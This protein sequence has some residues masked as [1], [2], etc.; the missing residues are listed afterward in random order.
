MKIV[1]LNEHTPVGNWGGYYKGRAGELGLAGKFML[2]HV[3]EYVNGGYGLYGHVYP[4]Q[5]AAELAMNGD[6]Q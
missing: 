1:L 3:G 4:T 5:E 6:Q 2:A